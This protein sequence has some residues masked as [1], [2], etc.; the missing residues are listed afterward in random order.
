MTNAGRQADS[1]DDPGGRES[2]ANHRAPSLRVTEPDLASESSPVT[3]PRNLCRSLGVTR[4][5]E[6]VIPDIRDTVA[7]PVTDW[8]RSPGLSQQAP[9]AGGRMREINGSRIS[10]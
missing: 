7:V 2:D 6:T 8:A 4:P 3:V 5:G 1:T 10:T 9:T